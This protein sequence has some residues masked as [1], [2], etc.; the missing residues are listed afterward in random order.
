MENKIMEYKREYSED[1]RKTVIAYANTDGGQIL[2]GVEDNGEIVGVNDPQ[3]DILRITNV[4]RDSIR[5]DVTLF[6][7]C[8][9]QLMEDRQIIVVEVQRGTARPYYLAGKGIR[10]EGVFVRQGASTVPATETAILSMIQETS[11][12]RYENARSLNQQLTFHEAEN[13][14]SKKGVA[15][16]ETQKKTLGLIRQDGFSMLCSVFRRCGP[17]TLPMCFIA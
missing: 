3:D 2:V 6:V 13:Y 12:N 17:R 16:E 15:F 1:I 4:I 10:P 9:I 7:D 8:R 5:P 11:G 14:F